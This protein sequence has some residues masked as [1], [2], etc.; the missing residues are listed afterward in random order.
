[1]SDKQPTPVSGGGDRTGKPDGVN[2]SDART[3]GGESG[4][5]GYDNPHTG[6][7]GN[8]DANGILGHGGQ[9]E[10]GYHG[11]G[12]AGSDGQATDNATAEGSSDVDKDGESGPKPG[13]TGPDQDFSAEYLREIEVDGRRLEIIDT[14]GIAAAEAAGTIGRDND[15]NG[16]D[17][18]GS[19]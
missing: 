16:S 5:G 11:G 15:A 10:I 3:A 1:M 19:G 9:T 17:A 13:P 6:K 2:E 4:G 18:P 12:Q 14:S 8:S 7:D